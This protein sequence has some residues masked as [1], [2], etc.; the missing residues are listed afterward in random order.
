METGS[1]QQPCPVG[2]IS[3]VRKLRT[4]EYGYV[5]CFTSEDAYKNGGGGGEAIPF[6]KGILA[7]AEGWTW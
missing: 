6:R 5:S 7:N 1:S 4:S 3:R 2:I